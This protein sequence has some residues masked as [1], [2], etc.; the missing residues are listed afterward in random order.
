MNKMYDA[1]TDCVEFKG[2]RYKLLLSIDQAELRLVVSDADLLY[3]LSANGNL[4]SFEDK[5]KFGLLVSILERD[6][7][8]FFGDLRSKCLDN[9]MF[10]RALNAVCVEKII[11]SALDARSSFW[12]EKSERW[13]H[14]LSQS[15][16]DAVREKYLSMKTEKWVPIMFRK[17]LLNSYPAQRP[18]GNKTTDQPL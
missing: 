9:D 11:I 3:A 13:L 12:V 8:S 6:P 1:L 10:Y 5:M 15:A 14:Y 18:Q 17:R 16:L 4:Y 2:K 7:E